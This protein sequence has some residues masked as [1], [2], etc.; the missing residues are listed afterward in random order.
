MDKIIRLKIARGFENPPILFWPAEA[1]F[2]W[3]KETPW[4]EL[5]DRVPIGE[6]DMASLIVRSADHLRQVAN[7]R[8]THP[9]LALVA[10]RAIDLI[11]REP[12]FIP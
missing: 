8:E 10:G 6:G 5:L 2:L 9:E 1:L 4:E 7:L 12:V 3:A 11:L